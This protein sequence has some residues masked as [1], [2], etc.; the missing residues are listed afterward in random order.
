MICNTY[1]ANSFQLLDRILTN[2]KVIN[3]ILVLL[4]KY[5]IVIK[6]VAEKSA[7]Q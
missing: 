6:K 2:F 3:L 1:H 5:N 7:R 4:Y